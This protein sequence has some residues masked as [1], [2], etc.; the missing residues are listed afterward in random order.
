MGQASTPRKAS[1]R[2]L[3]RMR[4]FAVMSH[5]RLPIR[6]TSVRSAPPRNASAAQP[7]SAA[8]ACPRS[9]ASARSM[10]RPSRIAG[11]HDRR[12]HG[13]AGQGA[14]QELPGYLAEV[15]LHRPGEIVPSLRG[16]SGPARQ[17][18]ARVADKGGNEASG[19]PEP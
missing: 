17:R 3:A 13:E 2:T 19:S 14:K 9:K 18:L 1:A 15:R 11:Q 5:H 10:A 8:P 7:T 6:G 12:V 4:A 16:R